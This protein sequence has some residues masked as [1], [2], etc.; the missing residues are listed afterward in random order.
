MSRASRAAALALAVLASAGAA[1]A[2]ETRAAKQKAAR[3]SEYRHEAFRGRIDFGIGR[4]A[5]Y[6]SAEG[7]SD[8]KLSGTTVSWSFAAGGAVTETC[9][10]GGILSFDRAFGIAARDERTGPIDASDVAVDQVLWG[11]MLDCY[12]FRTEGPRVFFAVG[13]SE[14]NVSRSAAGQSTAEGD[15]SPDPS[16]FGTMLGVGYDRFIGKE[17]SLGIVARVL[18]APLSVDETNETATVHTW[19]PM[20]GLSLSLD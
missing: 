4:L 17:T 14:L 6:G 15:P 1:E 12:L 18:Y 19:I 7:R 9:A 8:R 3:R 2:V 10:L 11:P 13:P 20:I 5:A 16:G